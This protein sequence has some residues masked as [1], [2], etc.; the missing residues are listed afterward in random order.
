MAN[1]ISCNALEKAFA[2]DPRNGETGVSIYTD[3]RW[4]HY[5]ESSSLYFGR[6]PDNLQRL[7]SRSGAKGYDFFDTLRVNERYFW[8]VDV[9]EGDLTARGDLWT[10]RTRSS[11]VAIVTG[12]SST[13]FTF[14]LLLFFIPLLF[15]LHK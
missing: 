3:L 5:G 1:V 11:S 2:P 9:H 4:D 7:L 13:S 10:F 6:D 14:S 15:I 8:R 12:C